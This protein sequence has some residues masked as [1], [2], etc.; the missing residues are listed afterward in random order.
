MSAFINRLRQEIMHMAP[1]TILVVEPDPA[2]AALLTD[3][4]PQYETAVV[5]NGREALSFCRSTPPSL[6]LIDTRLPD[7]DAMQLFEQLLPIKFMHRI[8]V[9]F[10]G[11]ENE[12]RERRMQALDLGVD[13]VITKPFD[14][15]EL[16]FRVKNALPS[17]AQQID[18]VTG[19]PDWPATYV[20]LNQ[21]LAKSNWSVIYIH[22]AYMGAY[23]DVHGTIAGQQMRRTVAHLLMA[24]VDELG[25][26]D[27]FIGTLGANDFVIL[28]RNPQPG[29]LAERFQ[30]RF[31]TACRQ[32]YTPREV[33]TERIKLADGR[34]IPI[35]SPA[36]TT[37]SVSGRQF[38]TPLQLVE[39]AE[40]QLRQTHP[41]AYAESLSPPLQAIFAIS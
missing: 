13:D 15:V 11:Q 22:I 41:H 14:I 16:Q 38:E 26:A 37:I 1:P 32:W 5:G 9:F 23:H 33:A 7:L 39:T 28:T 18:L 12:A 17:V 27:D 3:H 21:R 2:I 8:P 10:L 20:T 24:L 36:I 19:L 4:L 40:Q 35:M 30:E 25:Q 34:L 29:Q 6:I 31:R